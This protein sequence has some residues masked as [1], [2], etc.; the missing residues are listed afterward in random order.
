MA[1]S[2]DSPH[3]SNTEKSPDLL[4]DKEKDI[5]I[6]KKSSGQKDEN[7]NL[8]QE[9]IQAY[10]LKVTKEE[11]ARRSKLRRGEELSSDNESPKKK[12]RVSFLSTEPARK[13]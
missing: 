1:E 6:K 11:R 10:R 9:Q 3:N 4:S 8:R 5:A 2:Q 13:E 12:K 7:H